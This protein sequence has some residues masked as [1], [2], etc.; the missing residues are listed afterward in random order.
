[1]NRKLLCTCSLIALLPGSISGCMLV[2]ALLGTS[3]L[4]L[5]GPAQHIGTVC[6][7]GE[8]AY[9]LAVNKK[10]PDMVLR[11]KLSWLIKE[12]PQEAI[13]HKGLKKTPP[14]K[15]PC[16][17]QSQPPLEP[18]QTFQ[19]SSS[20]QPVPVSPSH[21]S[22]P[23]RSL[24]LSGSSVLNSPPR[25][26]GKSDTTRGQSAKG[27]VKKPFVKKTKNKIPLASRVENNFCLQS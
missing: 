27:L 13:P 19:F 7:V 10:T 15:E 9:E 8:Y 22:L 23:G 16:I 26:A 11:D 17:T 25:Q 18:S 3:S 1:M 14:S 12:R 20:M 2:N 4:V 6:T 5:S 24:S 21:T